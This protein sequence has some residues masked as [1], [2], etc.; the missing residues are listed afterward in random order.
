MNHI[1]GPSENDF[2]HTINSVEIYIP[3]H[4]SNLRDRF[5]FMDHAHTYALM[6]PASRQFFNKL[7]CILFA[8]S[9]QLKEQK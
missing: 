5:K 1:K 6:V 8:D 3:I 4:I 7:I 9:S 2:T